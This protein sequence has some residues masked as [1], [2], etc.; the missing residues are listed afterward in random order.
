MT[1][2]AQNPY[3]FSIVTPSLDQG[4]YIGDAITSVAVQG[5]LAFEHLIFDAVST[6]KTLEVLRRNSHVSHL[7]WT[8]EPDDGQSDA[9]NKGFLAAHGEIV[10]WLNADDYYLPGTFA[11]VAAAFAANP[12]LDVI[13]GEALFVD[14]SGNILRQKRDHRFDYGVL[15]YYGCYIMSTA[16]FFRR[17][18]IED[19]HLLDV[20]YRV[21]MD[22]EYFVRLANH[23]YKFGYIP[24][25]LA[26][27]RWHGSNVST[28]LEERR[29]AERLRVQQE[30]GGL[31]WIRSDALREQGF[32]ALKHL[33]LLRRHWLR[34]TGRLG[35]NYASLV[36]PDTRK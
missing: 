35:G 36:L 17:R 1:P 25:A 14:E 31:K 24:A 15:L 27:F 19:G 30:Y 29:R 28:R 9:I 12:E 34:A 18:V 32:S 16:T 20:S 26:A 10:A 11:R 13:Y 3:T 6:D 4:R 7:R 5:P 8:S 23:G 22:Y 2:R 33:Y 21:T